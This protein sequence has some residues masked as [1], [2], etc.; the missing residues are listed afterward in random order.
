MFSLYITQ[1]PFKYIDNVY[2]VSILS[3]E[4]FNDLLLIVIVHIT[5][6]R[7]S[8]LIIMIQSTHVII[9]CYIIFI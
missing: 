8:Y 5:I 6:M 1:R 9:D 2:N 7:V 3:L 4:T